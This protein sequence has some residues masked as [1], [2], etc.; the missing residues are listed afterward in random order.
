MRTRVFDNRIKKGPEDPCP[1]CWLPHTCTDLVSLRSSKINILFGMGQRISKRTDAS[2]HK[3]TI[4][5]ASSGR[6]TIFSDM[7]DVMSYAN[8][9]SAPRPWCN[10]GLRATFENV[11]KC[12][13]VFERFR[14][15]SA[16][17]SGRPEESHSPSRRNSFALWHFENDAFYTLFTSHYSSW[18][19]RVK[20][21][22]LVNKGFACA[23]ALASHSGTGNFAFSRN[24][25]SRSWYFYDCSYLMRTSHRKYF[26][27]H[28]HGDFIF[29]L[30]F[31]IS[32]HKWRVFVVVRPGWFLG[33]YCLSYKSGV[34]AYIR[35]CF[36]GLIELRA[37][38]G[39][40]RQSFWKRKPS[41]A[42]HVEMTRLINTSVTFLPVVLK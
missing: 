33:V 16:N 36:S 26:D 34:R 25:N 14:H 1:G 20:F 37:A 9:F 32:T 40:G 31:Q 39:R 29:T 13:H 18:K 30:F 15:R 5:S 24:T 41:K 38:P 4:R 11:R 42:R 35:C 17:K 2:W 7:K 23:R 8:F 19:R 27:T 10:S 6:I 21:F 3:K 28:C 12:S 22:S